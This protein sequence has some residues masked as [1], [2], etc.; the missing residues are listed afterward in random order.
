MTPPKPQEIG[1]NPEPALSKKERRDMEARFV[2]SLRQEPG[3]LCIVGLAN[4]C[5][6]T[7]HQSPDPRSS[8]VIR[9]AIQFLACDRTLEEHIAMTKSLAQ[10][11]CDLKDPSIKSLHESVSLMDPL[12]FAIIEL[13]FAIMDTLD[14]KPNAPPIPDDSGIRKDLDRVVL[15]MTNWIDLMD[16]EDQLGPLPADWD[17]PEELRPKVNEPGPEPEVDPDEEQWPSGPEEV[18]PSPLGLAKTLQNL[19]YWTGERS[20]SGIFLLVSR[21]SDYAPSFAEEMYRSQ[22]AIPCG[23]VHLQQALD[24]FEQKEPPSTFRLAIASVTHFL[25]QMPKPHFLP[26]LLDFRDILLDLSIR[27]QPAL[28]RMPGPEAASAKAWWA[29]IRLGLDAGP[30]FPWDKFAHR[31]PASQFVRSRQLYRMM[32]IHRARKCCMKP[33]CPNREAPLKTVMFC[34]R[35]MLACYCDS[36]CQRKAWSKGPAPHKS[37]C[38]AVD[39]L[40]KS[41]GLD[42]NSSQ[43]KEVLTR[44]TEGILQPEDI[45]AKICKTKKIKGQRLQTIADLLT[46][47]DAAMPRLKSQTTSYGLLLA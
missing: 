33:D 19:L 21:L 9:A 5:E 40:R 3:A 45:F 15:G 26:L 42:Q 25:H 18:F 2:S 14:R 38:D 23:L 34:G 16:D 32:R 29:S 46:T 13:C 41:M 10:C 30:A 1:P 12:N 11:R 44:R 24:R 37:L 39:T 43:W 20:G 27:V 4:C 36:A 31:E 6:K 47:H 28:A 22:I 17:L 8:N 7:F 35:C